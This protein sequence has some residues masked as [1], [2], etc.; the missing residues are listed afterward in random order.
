MKDVLISDKR[1]LE[2]KIKKISD[3]GKNKFHVIAD[4]D[5]TLTKAFVDGQ[6][7]P[8]VIAQIREGKYLTPD[9]SMRAHKLFDIYHPIE[10]DSNISYEEKNSKM[11]EWWRKHFDLLV[12]CGLNKQV[13]EEIIRTKTLKFREGSLEFLSALNENDIP[14]VIMSAGPGDMISEYIKQE[15][16]LYKNIHIIAN[17]F[18]F[19]KNGKVTGVKEPIIHSLNKHEIELKKLLVYKELLKRK[20]ILLLGD[21]LDDLGM[22]EGFPY[23]NLIKVG[24]LNENV[25]KN[26]SK[27]KET[28]DVV[29]LNDGNMD[30]VNDLFKRLIRKN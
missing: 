19:D 8:T 29:V 7:S 26:L 21:G 10:I 2:K 3:Q 25:D 9:Y 16:K 4:F 5:R 28:Y 23:T 27:F 20:N 22:V 11:N 30:Y 12:E 15:N 1:E 13:I 14:L 18:I 17:M 24:F 6:K